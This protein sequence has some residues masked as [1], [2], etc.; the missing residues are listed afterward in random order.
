[1]HHLVPRI[2]VTANGVTM[3]P[4]AGM[5]PSRAWKDLPDLVARRTSWSGLFGRPIQHAR[6]VATWRCVEKDWQSVSQS[7]RSIQIVILYTTS[8]HIVFCNANTTN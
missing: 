7:K 2:S 4:V 1:M 3:D 8:L 5:R 6:P